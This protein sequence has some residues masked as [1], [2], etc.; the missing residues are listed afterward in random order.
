MTAGML[1]EPQLDPSGA[2]LREI[3]EDA[4]VAALVSGRVRGV[5]PGPNDVGGAGD[6]RSFV[7]LTAFDVP[8]HPRLPVTFADYGIRAYGT[9]PQNAWEV[10]AAIVKAIHAV[11]PRVKTSGLGFYR[12]SVT[13]G[14]REELDPDTK[15][16]VVSGTVRLIAT[17]LA[18]Q[19]AGS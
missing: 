5:Q 8:P 19:T 15:Q 12:S 11:G 2:L 3:R 4:D 13:D 6:Y 17:T 9:T 10:W 18:V 16:P 14:G 1:T 7:V